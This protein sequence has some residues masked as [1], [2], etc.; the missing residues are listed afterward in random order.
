M[1]KFVHVLGSGI[2]NIKIV[3]NFMSKEDHQTILNYLNEMSTIRPKEIMHWR[4]GDDGFRPPE[5]IL[6]LC[7]DYYFKVVE[8]AKEQYK[9]NFKNNKRKRLTFTIHAVGSSSDPHT[10][11]VES[12]KDPQEPGGKEFIGWRDGWDGYLACNIYIN[13]NYEGGQ[14]YFP[15]IPYEIKPVANS[16]VMWAGN[17]NYIHGVKDPLTANRYT[18]TTWIKFKD[19]EQYN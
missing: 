3:E 6:K 5:D 10:D 13:D 19:F 14:V 15:E 2:Q 4:M 12:V 8:M 17:K 16:L 9:T 1:N 7:Y 11:I 18:W